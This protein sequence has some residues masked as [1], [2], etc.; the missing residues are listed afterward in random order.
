M[1]VSSCAEYFETLHSRFVASAA[2]GV[3]AIYQFE[4]SGPDGGTWHIIVDDGKMEVKEGAHD[5]PSSVVTAKAA[6]YVK[7][8]SGTMNGLRAVM[9]R[10]MKI[11]GNLV[12]ARKMQQMLP[13]G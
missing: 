12:L 4:L 10:K 6:D 1:P 11:S 9:T 5:S 13:T 3:Q 2:A 7:I 8:A